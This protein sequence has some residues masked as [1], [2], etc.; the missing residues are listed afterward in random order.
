[1][2]RPTYANLMAT[3]AMF[4]ALGGTSYAVAKLPKGSVGERELR[5]GAVT[6]P[7]L[8][9]GAVTA[10]K[11]ATGIGTRGPRGTQGPAGPSDAWY[12]AGVA[13]SVTLSPKGGEPVTAARLDDL[14]PGK[15]VF[16]GTVSVVAH[17]VGQVFTYCRIATNGETHG[18]SVGVFGNA[19]G[20]VRAAALSPIGAVTMKEDF[21]AILECWNDRD[22]PADVTPSFQ[23]IG[24]D[25]IRVGALN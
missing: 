4:V 12:S 16:H 19:A 21:R 23:Q 2:F 25:A 11:L 18:T 15:Y 13:P 6:N 8:A 24:F 17:N 7:K 22:T 20:S 3:A 10:D 14:P 5:S 9:R 1:M